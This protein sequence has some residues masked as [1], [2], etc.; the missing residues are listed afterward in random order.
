MQ[1]A[2]AHR[3]FNLPI[4]S[5][6]LDQWTSIELNH[7]K[8]GGNRNLRLFL[9]YYSIPNGIKREVVFVSKIMTYYRK[10]VY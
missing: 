6:N 9:N 5:I 3:S 1:C 10:R 8:E 4:K 7:M 2:G